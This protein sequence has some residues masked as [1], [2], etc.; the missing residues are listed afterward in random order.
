M[1]SNRSKTLQDT[2]KFVHMVA[3]HNGWAINQDPAFLGHLVQ[4][5]GLADLV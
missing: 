5:L 1:A 4:G 3:D 2:E